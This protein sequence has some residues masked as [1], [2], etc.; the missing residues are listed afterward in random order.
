MNAKAIQ[1]GPETTFALVFDDGEEV[2]S[3]LQAFAQE[4]GV[5]GAHFTAIGAFREA[6]LG[7]FD[8]KRKAYDKIAIP[9]QVEVLALAG[10]VA[11]HEGKPKVHAHAVVGKR[12]GTAHG[13]HLLRAHVR[14]TLEV[15]LV[16]LSRRLQRR[17]DP[18]T[19]LPLLDL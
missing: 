2:M 8:L 9:E 1:D 7:F 11:L 14:P 10:N 18:K 5:T 19:G 17:T 6:V 3:G 12:D 4:H 13:G 16:E 15:V